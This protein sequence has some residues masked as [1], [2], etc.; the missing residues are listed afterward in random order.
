MTLKTALPYSTAASP[1]EKGQN[2][3][4]AAWRLDFK[5]SIIVSEGDVPGAIREN[6][7]QVPLLLST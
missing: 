2:Q 1:P 7:D 5:Q 4:A 6:K 3:A